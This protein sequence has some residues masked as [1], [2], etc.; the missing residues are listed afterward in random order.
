MGR[1][2]LQ[3]LVVIGR[4]V[5]GA[6]PGQH[7][8][9]L[10]REDGVR[11]HEVGLERQ[12]RPEPVA[13]RAGAERVVEREQPRLDLGDREAGN[14]AGELRGE[15][16]ALRAAVGFGLA[17]I[18]RDGDAVG[19]AERGFHAVGEPTRHVGTHHDAVDHDVDVVL[20]LLVERRRVF[21]L[22]EGAVDLDALEALLLQVR[23]FLPVLALAAAHHRGKQVEPRAFRQREDAVHHLRNGLALDRQAGRGGIGNADARPEQA[24][25]VVDLGDGA[26]GRAW[27]ARSGLLL[28]GDRRGQSVDLIDVRLLHHLQELAG[29]GRQALDIAPLAFGIDG[30]EGERRLAGARKAR[31]HHQLVAGDIEVDVLEI[32]LACAA[33]RNPASFEIAA[34]RMCRYARVRAQE[35]L[36]ARAAILRP[37]IAGR[38]EQGVRRRGRRLAGRRR[39]ARR[40]RGSVRRRFG[41]RFDPSGA[42]AGLPFARDRAGPSPSD[43]DAAGRR[44]RRG[45]SRDTV[46]LSRHANKASTSREISCFRRASAARRGA[47]AA[48]RQ[49]RARLAPSR[50][51]LVS[52]DGL[53]QHG[54]RRSP[55]GRRVP[56]AAG[57]E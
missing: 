57:W 16:H 53:H 29:I 2:R 25:I 40:A 55:H 44:R 50:L 14:G 48:S 24:H 35:S 39:G 22:V 4:R 9:L 5:A 11:H 23:Q 42:E 26:D 51:A 27:I 37:G 34:G 41:H 8:A 47:S 15:D 30:V 19:E 33:N 56:A 31:E 52:H 21:D 7:R 43:P 38:L 17:G 28:D 45:R 13:G 18:F 12:R 20:Q 49:G 6:R 1:D 32:V 46:N 3:G 36:G 10:Q 54:K